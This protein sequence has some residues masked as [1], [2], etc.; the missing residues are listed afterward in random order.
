[1]LTDIELKAIQDAI[2]ISKKCKG[3]S[4][5]KPKVGAVLIKDGKIIE[6]AYR[7]ELKEGEHAEY[8]LLERK[9]KDEDVKGST[10][11]T[12]LEPCTNRHIPKRPCA[13]HIEKRGIKKVIIGMLDPNPDIIYKGYYYLKLVNIE[14]SLFLEEDMKKMEEINKEF[15]NSQLKRYK[16]GIYA[17]LHRTEPT[18]QGIGNITKSIVAGR[19]MKIKDSDIRIE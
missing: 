13:F 6:S 8:T 7:G 12:T 9:L 18:K 4:R 10:L 19:D 3:E 5:D 16:Q 1:M 2:D 11:V 15:I 14:V 17:E